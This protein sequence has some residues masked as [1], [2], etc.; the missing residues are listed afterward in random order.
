MTRTWLFGAIKS[1]GRQELQIEIKVV[2]EK[3]QILTRF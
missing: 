2:L 1:V 3:H